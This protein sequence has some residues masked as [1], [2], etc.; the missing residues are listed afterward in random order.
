MLTLALLIKPASQDSKK[1]CSIA[2]FVYSSI[3]NT[4]NTYEWIGHTIYM[5]SIQYQKNIS[6]I[7]YSENLQVEI[8][9]K[10]CKISH[11]NFP[12]RRE[13]QLLPIYCKMIF[14]SIFLYLVTCFDLHTR[15]TGGNNM[16]QQKPE[17][18]LCSKNFVF[19]F[20]GLFGE[21]GQL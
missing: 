6:F 16:Y 12:W 17:R 9:Q 8:N 18:D 7:Y 21:G 3:C 15:C 13:K 11:Q 14:T 19:W 2:I 4:S 1:C 10:Q 20:L 5:D